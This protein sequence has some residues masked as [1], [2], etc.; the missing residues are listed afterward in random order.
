M[1]KLLPLLLL[2]FLFS[3]CKKVDDGV[4]DSEYQFQVT[5]SSCTIGIKAGNEVLAYNVQGYLA[6][7]YNSTFP[8]ITVSL[9]T[10]YD[11]DATTV[12]FVGSGYNT[13]LF[14]GDLYYDDPAT[15]IDL[16]L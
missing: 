14:D 13:I 1:K 6:I 4:P 10:D 5:C 11:I 9:Y 16:N 7:P 8:K 15:I 2:C 3:S 12:K